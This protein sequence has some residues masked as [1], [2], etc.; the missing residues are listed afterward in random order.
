[1]N[2]SHKTRRILI[3]FF[4]FALTLIPVSSL[5][6]W[7]EG[8]LDKQGHKVIGAITHPPGDILSV[9][10]AQL[11]PFLLS[12]TKPVLIFLF[13]WGILVGLF[14]WFATR[15]KIRDIKFIDTLLRVIFESPRKVF[16][17]TIFIIMLCYACL[18]SYKFNGLQP[19]KPDSSAQ[20]FQ[21]RI[22]A[23]GNLY[24]PPPKE[25]EFF[26]FPF[27]MPKGDK[28]FTLYNP[29]HPFML[30]LGLFLGI[31][32]IIN[33]LTGAFSLVLLYKIARQ[34]YDEKTA[35]LAT[36]MLMSSPFY[37]Y[38]NSGYMNN[39]SNLF[40]I[41]LFIYFYIHSFN[42][43]RLLA[44]FAS[45]FFLGAAANVR[46]LTTL[47]IGFSFGLYAFIRRK[48]IDLLIPK[49]LIFTGGS[50]ITLGILF[51]YNY[52][53]NGNP[54]RFNYSVYHKMLDPNVITLGFGPTPWGGVHTPFR[55]FIHILQVINELNQKMFSW[56]FASLV[57]IFLFFTLSRKFTSW[58]HL[59]LL[60]ALMVIGTHFFFFVIRIR[61]LYTIVPLLV[62]LSARGAINL[63]EILSH[64]TWNREGI[65][66]FTILFLVLCSSL[67]QIQ[68]VLPD[69]IHP[70]GEKKN[71]PARLVAKYNIHNAIV[72][73]EGGY[74]D[75]GIYIYAF[76]HLQPK[77]E[78]NDV[79][80]ALDLKERNYILAQKYPTRKT[81]RLLFFKNKII[82][83]NPFNSKD[84]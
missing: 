42:T 35:R 34:L 33:P 81:Y 66:I 6:E 45:G 39:P 60:T 46:P 52:L 14:W 21:A 32:W 18:F 79:I 50:A 67:A 28:W 11:K 57:L 70:L 26:Y 53:T 65:R 3:S 49:S 76:N 7:Y 64:R 23:S 17:I 13:K 75:W 16:Q 19:F 37:L 30:M 44:P 80:Y 63:P 40:F 2:E 72:F 25:K 61:Y 78:E 83:Y 20:L 82:P 51:S 12:F 74:G 8:I 47:I 68:S 15:I 36:I 55:G 48:D 54:L 9:F 38:W 58:D 1:M 77:I 59:L 62:L 71:K 43:N 69:I 41:L 31:P 27:L 22:F 5:T 24:L 73:L 84:S 10:L 56:P 29:G 4:L